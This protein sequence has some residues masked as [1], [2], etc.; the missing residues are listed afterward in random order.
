MHKAT[1][2]NVR[3]LSSLETHVHTHTRA[4][5]YTRWSVFH[6]RIANARTIALNAVLRQPGE[7]SW[8]TRTTHQRP[9]SFN[10]CRL[11]IISSTSYVVRSRLRRN[12]AYT[13]TP[14]LSAFHAAPR[15]SL[16][17][18]L[19]A[20]SSS[21]LFGPADRRRRKPTIEKTVQLRD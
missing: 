10:V 21:S 9:C 6:I 1:L 19:L 5:N 15:S 11:I 4:Y 13:V 20:A 8:T 18:G 14:A 16:A 12:A 7:R 17:A 3:P 2:A